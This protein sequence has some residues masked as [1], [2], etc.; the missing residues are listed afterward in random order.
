MAMQR[1]TRL[2]LTLLSRALPYGAHGRL[3][4]RRE[5][6]SSQRSSSRNHP[7]EKQLIAARYPNDEHPHRSLPTILPLLVAIR[8]TALT[9]SERLLMQEVPNDTLYGQ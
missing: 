7:D 8:T 1:A 4:Q 5:T 9:I 6:L 2:P 3:P